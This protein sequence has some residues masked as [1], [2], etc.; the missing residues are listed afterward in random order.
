[1]RLYTLTNLNVGYNGTNVLHDVTLSIDSGERVALVGPS[2][3]GKSTLLS[4]LY[5]Q[6]P[7]Q[8]AFVPQ[9]YALVRPLSVFHNVYMGS[10]HRHSAAYNL[11]NLVH[12]L[13]REQENTAPVL[14]A[15]GLLDKRGTPVGELSGGQQQRTAVGRALFQGGQVLLADEPVSSIDPVQS[16]TV[17]QTINDAFDTV[18]LAMHDTE[19]ALAFTG[20]VIGLKGGRI[21][22][23]R[24]SAGLG[25]G[26]LESL[27]T[28]P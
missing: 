1:M 16:R 12:P 5:R 24:P 3:A 10:L 20:R 7:R 13:R 26:D 19:L 21:L 2:G 22:L 14:E 28:A 4:T 18:V 6:Q 17:L 25:A 15:L 9:D 8:T 27:Y 23:D 11:L